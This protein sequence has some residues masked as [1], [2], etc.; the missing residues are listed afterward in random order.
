M[1]TSN[2]FEENAYKH[3][4]TGAEAE[5]RYKVAGALETKKVSKVPFLLESIHRKV[6][7]FK[8][9]EVFHCDN[10]TGFKCD[11]VRVLKKHDVDIRRNTT[12]YKHNHK[13]FVEA[14]NEELPKQLFKLTPW[15]CKSFITLKR[16]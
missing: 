6:G 7:L 14:F 1:C 13:I 8:Y 10:E 2:V 12:K 11:V 5:S 16:Y 9:P 3:I 4:S 15:M